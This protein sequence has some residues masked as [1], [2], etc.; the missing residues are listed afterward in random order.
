MSDYKPNLR[1]IAC[2]IRHKAHLASDENGG[3]CR[4]CHGDV[5]RLGDSGEP[6]VRVWT[7]LQE[8][9]FLIHDPGDGKNLGI[10]GKGMDAKFQTFKDS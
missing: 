10:I 6:A 4:Y 2:V 7:L 9:N 3:A 8:V 1:E 5:H